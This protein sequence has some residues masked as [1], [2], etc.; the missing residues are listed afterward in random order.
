MPPAFDMAG[1]G[2]AAGLA[3]WLPAPAPRPDPAP[4]VVPSHVMLPLVN[5]S[6]PLQYILNPFV[7]SVMVF[8]TVPTV[9]LLANTE[10]SSV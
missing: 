3:N 5:V 7:F 1:S 6:V 9:R 8:E 2:V 10:R 4:P